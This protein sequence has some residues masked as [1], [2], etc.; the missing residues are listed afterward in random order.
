MTCNPELAI[1]AEPLLLVK[2]LFFFT[3]ELTAS[4]DELIKV[5]SC[6]RWLT[7]VAYV[8]CCSALLTSVELR[9]S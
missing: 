1:D 4:C 2:L 8:V 3:E 7:R 6:A 9:S 5:E